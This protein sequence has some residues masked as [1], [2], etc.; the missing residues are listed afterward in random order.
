MHASAI[1]NALRNVGVQAAIAAAVLFGAGMPAAKL[2]LGEVSPWLLAGLLYFGSGVGLWLLRKSRGLP[3]VSVPPH[4]RLW[5]AGAV[6]AGGLV[7]PVL[8]MWGLAGM[9]ASGASLLLNAEG[10]FT[11]LI[12][13]Y[14]FRENCD[15]R[16]ALGMAAIVAGA[17]VLSWPATPSF[18]SAAPALGVLGACL[19]W[20]IDNN[21]TRRVS[22]VDAT[23][24]AMVKGLA[25][26]TVNLGLALL[27]GASLPAFHIAAAAFA[28]GF[29]SYG[30]SLVL[31]VVAL[32]H[33]GTARTGAYFSTGPFFGS[34]VSIVALG[35]PLT[36]SVV[37][38]G[39]L[40]AVGVWLHLTERHDHLH[41]HEPMEHSHEHEHDQHH[42]HDHVPSVPPGV[43]HGHWHKHEPLSHDHGHYPDAHHRHHH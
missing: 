9:S 14:I 37:I 4:E 10:V 5:L 42:R 12:A 34:A 21:L 40:M 6:V 16:I 8:L 22:L 41:T 38:A 29:V 18:D 26:G 35:E 27:V 31:F 11:A 25:A 1:V 24:V 43:R 3:S 33:L 17:I 19:A 13:W 30:V 32:R 7:G 28:L 15:R 20:G 39:A 36:G 2:L 23:F